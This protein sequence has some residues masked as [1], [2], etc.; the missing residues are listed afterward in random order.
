MRELVARQKVMVLEDY[1]RAVLPPVTE[2]VTKHH[3]AP[4]IYM[5]EFHLPAGV[6][7]TGKIHRTE[8]L[9]VIVQGHCSVNCLGKELDIN[10]VYSFVSLAGVKKAVYAHTDTV[11]MTVHRTDEIDLDR[12]EEEVIVESFAQ[13]DFERTLKIGEN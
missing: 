7:V 6:V 3:F 4:G 12:I 1:I 9:N 5:R 11:W 10:A 2:F 8:H 13:V